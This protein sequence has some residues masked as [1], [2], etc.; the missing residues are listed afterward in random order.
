[1]V[2]HIESG[3]SLIVAALQA[4]GESQITGVDHIDRGYEDI[5][6]SLDSIGAVIEYN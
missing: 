2:L 1:M 6:S 3:A 4:E 5:V